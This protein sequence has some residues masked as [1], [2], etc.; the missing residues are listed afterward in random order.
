MNA[1]PIA[2]LFFAFRPQIRFPRLESRHDVDYS[3]PSLTVLPPRSGRS[4]PGS[5]L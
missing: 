2:V 5:R 3:K 1:P 4:P